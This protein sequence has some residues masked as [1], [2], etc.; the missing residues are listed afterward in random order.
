MWLTDVPAERGAMRVLTGSH[1]PIMEHWDRV[2]QPARWEFLSRVH[3]L[4]TASQ[5]AEYALAKEH[6]ADVAAVFVRYK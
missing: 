5:N 3:G 1:K 2:L 4:S 6:L